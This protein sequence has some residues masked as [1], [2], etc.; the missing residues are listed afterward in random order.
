MVDVSHVT[1]SPKAEKFADRRAQL[2]AS[3]LRTLA[4]L[5]YARTSLREIAQNSEFS[6]GVMHSYFR[7]KVELITYCVRLY[8]DE[9]IAHYDQS[10]ATTQNAAE[11]RAE[12]GDS[13]A[14]TLREDTMM[15]RL[16]FD[17]R[18]QS[19]FEES[20]RDDMREIDA[21]LERMIGRIVTRYAELTGSTPAVPSRV[22]YGM[23][24][25]L[26]HQALLEHLAGD[27]TAAAELGEDVGQVLDRLVH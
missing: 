2:A 15:H 6:H 7:D 21:S 16:W 8:K 26:F 27:E 5:G 23:L 11:L 13:M 24:Y 19:L 14:E 9:L 1:S 12:L 10:V 4:E 3:A 18:N 25:G 20:F 17:L 22:A